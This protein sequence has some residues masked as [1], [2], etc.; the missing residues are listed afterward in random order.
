[1][2]PSM[3]VKVEFQ[4]TMPSAQVRIDQILSGGAWISADT[5]QSSRKV[6][7]VLTAV[8]SFVDRVARRYPRD[9]LPRKP[10]RR[11]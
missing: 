7:R 3:L 5:V 9:D 10:G 1:M 4:R 2:F 6:D 11:R 8:T